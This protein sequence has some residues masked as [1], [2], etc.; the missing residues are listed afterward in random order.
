M[1]PLSLHENWLQIDVFSIDWFSY[2][3]PLV[4]KILRI[5]NSSS[6]RED[7]SQA[8]VE[9]QETYGIE[10][11]LDNVRDKSRFN[12][13]RES[14]QSASKLRHNVVQKKNQSL[15]PGLQNKS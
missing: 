6:F 8:A 1:L 5:D 9:E 4:G 2:L 7:T 12:K 3:Q 13:K 14:I 11:A 10:L 15:I